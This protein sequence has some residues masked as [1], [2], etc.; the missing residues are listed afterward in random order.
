ME[1]TNT[2]TSAENIA[3][4]LKLLEEAAKQ[5]KDELKGVMSDKYTHLRNLIVETEGG[6]VK[7]LSDAKTH[8]AETVAHVKDVSVEKAH[9]I[10]NTLD[11]SAHQNPWPYIAGSAVF[12]LL[13]G[14][15]L[16]RG[17]K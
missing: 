5:K 7:S 15:L 14:G 8:A 17:S 1:N 16:G 12:G 2:N 3:E 4:A 6:F 10:A 9:E 13:L 11:K